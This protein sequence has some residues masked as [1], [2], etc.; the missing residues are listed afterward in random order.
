M[1]P[2]PLLG[3]I[4]YYVF[5][6]HTH[7]HTLTHKVTRTADVIESDHQAN[8]ISNIE[9]TYNVGYGVCDEWDPEE[10]PDRLGAWRNE[11]DEEDSRKEECYI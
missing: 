6:I 9:L 10:I 7:T 4:Y 3:S 8:R 5:N 2:T 11:L 1:S